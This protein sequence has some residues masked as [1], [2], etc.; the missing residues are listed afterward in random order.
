MAEGTHRHN[1]LQTEGIF[2]CQ[3]R[4][5]GRIQAR[6]GDTDSVGARLEGPSLALA[7]VPAGAVESVPVVPVVGY[8]RIL[9][10]SSEEEV[11]M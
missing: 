1:R 10:C 7:A 5:G 8:L 2:Q 4:A 6:G 11:L 9:V 3:G